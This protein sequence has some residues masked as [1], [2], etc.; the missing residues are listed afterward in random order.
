M[1]NLKKEKNSIDEK[2]ESFPRFTSIINIHTGAHE[3]EKSTH[4][5]A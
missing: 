5:R 3:V 4:K 2:N 1:S